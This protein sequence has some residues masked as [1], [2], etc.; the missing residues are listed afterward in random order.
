MTS[1]G[2]EESSPVVE[3]R[4]LGHRF[5]RHRLFEG[6]DLDVP[7]GAV[8]GLLGRNGTGKTTTLQLLMGLLRRQEGLVKVLGHDPAR[9]PL[10]VRAQVGYVPERPRFYPWMRV[11]ELIG[12]VARHR[13]TWDFVWAEELGELFGLDPERRIGELSKGENALLALLVAVAFRPPLLLLDEPAQGLDPVAR[14]RFFEGVLAGYGEEGGTVLI[15]SHLIRDISTLVDHVAILGR[16]GLVR[17]SSVETLRRDVRAFR[18]V[19][20][21]AAGND[22]AGND[23]AGNDPAGND[24]LDALGRIAG[25]RLL[26]VERFGR[27]QRVVV[28]LSG[29][30]SS[31]EA[32][33]EWQTWRSAWGETARIEEESLDLEEIFFALVGGGL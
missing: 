31:G 21:G 8:F 3:L 7:R 23:P 13:P 33:A 2:K 25:L 1:P 22:T 15:S 26:G 12:F 32:T 24:P 4:G 16:G 18:M 10:A 30:D 28:D 29:Q 5:G 6:L 11:G 17:S 19:A 9:E 27:R 20:T 14:R